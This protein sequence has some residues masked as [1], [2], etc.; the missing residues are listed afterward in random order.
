MGWVGRDLI[1]HLVPNTLLWAGASSTRPGCSK[2]CP[3]WPW[4]LPGASWLVLA[5][6]EG[7]VSHPSPH[8]EVLKA[9]CPLLQVGRWKGRKLLGGKC[10]FTLHI[11]LKKILYRFSQR[12]VAPKR[13]YRWRCRVGHKASYGRGL[14]KSEDMLSESSVVMGWKSH[15]LWPA[16]G[17]EGNGA[18]RVSPA[19]LAPRSV[20]LSA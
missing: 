18:L 7:E 19:H 8:W 16:P 3:A 6:G 20:L 1:D 2:P 11:Y 14:G 12:Q 5:S 9:A 15:L 13:S 4:T 17:C 10:S